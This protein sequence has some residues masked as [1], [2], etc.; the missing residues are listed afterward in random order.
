MVSCA[1]QN[2]KGDLINIDQH[3]MDEEGLV[4][5]YVLFLVPV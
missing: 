1:L 4:L 3:L 5:G 2:S